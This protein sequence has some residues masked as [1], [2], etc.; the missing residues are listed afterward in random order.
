MSGPTPVTCETAEGRIVNWFSCGAASAIA[1]MLTLRDLRG[2]GREVVIV[3]CITG[4]EDE[5][6]ARF[7][8]D[9][10]RRFN[11]PVIQIRSDKY[12]S[13]WDVWEKRKF[14]SGPK[15]APCTTHLKI[16]PRLEFQRPDDIHVFGYTADKLDA[17]LAK[18]FRET[19]FELTVMTP[20]I[21]RG[22]DKRACR[23]MLAG[24]GIAEPRT[25]AEGFPN[26][27]CVESGCGKATSPDYWALHRLRRPEGF[28][29]TAAIA[30]KLGARLARI[31]DERVFIDDIP[32]DWP[33]LNPEAP[34]CDFMCA[35][36]EQ[37]IAS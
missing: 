36:A 2:Q 16:E 28:A 32:A 22:L 33:I 21:D 6:N 17:N 10:E 4:S 29:R 35:I 20:L 26:A 11:Q 9:C 12:S 7:R 25:Y 13:T 27:N 8:T 5:D 15:G 34:Y 37:D 19:W 23:A 31:N 30:R 3:E 1:T 14:I 18:A 24:M